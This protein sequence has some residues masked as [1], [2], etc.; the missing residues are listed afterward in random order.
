[1][2]GGVEITVFR[3]SEGVL[4][5]RISLS[6]SGKVRS[7]G[8]EC[9]MTTGIA[10]RVKLNGPR[11]LAKLIDGLG[12]DEALALGR[13]RADLPNEVPV[14]VKRN[15]NRRT[16]SNTIARSGDYLTFAPGNPAYLLLDHDRKGTPVGVVSKLKEAGGFWKV[17]T[18]TIPDLTRA[19]HVSRPSTSAGLFHEE[20]NERLGG[21]SNRHVYVAV[22]DGTD[23]ERALK[24][25]H[26][27]L[28]LAGFGYFVVGAVGQLLDR[29]II[30]ASVYGPERLV[31]EGAPILIWPV[32]QD[33]EMRRPKVRTGDIIDT[34]QAI[35]AL[36]E[37]EAQRLSELKAGAARSLK[38]VAENAR[39]AWAREFA[40]L[41]GFSEEKAERIAAQATTHHVLE[42]EFELEFDDPD[43][44]VCTVADVL[45]DSNKYVDETMADPLE[46]AAYGPH[47]AKIYRQSDGRL[48]I[49]SFAHGGIKYK[50]AGQGNTSDPPVQKLPV[51]QVVDG[52]IA[53][54]V[55]EAQ[56]ALMRAGLSIF[57]SGGRM[58]EPITVEREAADG[59][60]TSSTVLTSI[61]ERKI[62]Y[63]LNKRAAVFKRFDG[64]SNAWRDINPPPLVAATLLSL[65]KWRFPEVIGVL[66]APTMRPDGMLLSKYGYDPQTRLWCDA[67]MTLPPIPE[68]PTRQDAMI[69]L[70]RFEHLLSGFPFAREVDKAVALA[71]VLTVALRGAF[72]FTPMFLITAHD[73]S[74]GK[75]YLVDLLAT[76]ATGRHCPV[77][78]AG[79]TNDE[80]EK[81]LGGVLLEG[82]SMVSLDNLSFDLESDLL[83]QVLTQRI[84]KVRVLGKSDVPECEWRGTIFA[85][86]N[87]VRALGDLVR[88][89]LTC[90]LDAKVERPELREFTFDPIARVRGDQEDYIAA[91]ITI[92][93]AYRAAGRE[94]PNFRPLAG[95]GPW[96]A[97]V[98]EPLLWLGVHDPVKSME[99][100][101]A[102]DPAR[103]AAY[104]LVR[105]W[106]TCIGINKPV[107]ARDIISIANQTKDHS[108]AHR[109]PKFR[110]LLLEH[111]G[112]AKRDEVDPVRLGKWLHHQSGRVYEELRIDLVSHKGRPNEYVL[113]DV[114]DNLGAEGDMV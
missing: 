62:S 76:L 101:R 82:G 10:R 48:M 15:L 20:T 7:D 13:L 83:C 68:Q 9:R 50:L 65:K 38:S 52:Q 30:D 80:L 84:V 26:S 24:T 45:A 74:N 96:S 47:K 14:V 44:G 22:K 63:S 16:K 64:R 18:A 112:T 54:I 110:A 73:V 93:R 17:I 32:T 86:G 25:L 40:A 71:A 21:S 6:K 98:R 77:I 102:A 107:S 4:S 28:W 66:G 85:T 11:S 97:A 106:K 99:A 23:I 105:R 94:A 70:R 53:R 111:A 49:N 109:F 67:D 34:A 89:T 39:R 3:K 12:S 35:P 72:D 19:A 100:A 29:T 57:V 43:L 1:M 46:G 92:A 95:Y 114:G 81:R 31:F 37:Q 36:T 75:S 42:A 59:R 56:D 55:D 88:R 8:S 104:Q 69:A 103:A 79:K 113:V 58:V 33:Q 78:T 5:K 27:R 61:D 87:N 90:Q 51:I 108:V 2:M 41:R 60:T 91:A